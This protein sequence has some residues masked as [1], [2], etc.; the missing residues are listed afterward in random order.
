MRDVEVTRI[1]Y[2][3]FLI[4]GAEI[5][6]HIIL[7]FH[8]V[9]YALEAVLGVGN[10]SRYEVKFLKLEGDNSSL[11]GVLALDAVGDGERLFL[12]KNGSTRVALALCGKPIGLIA[13]GGKIRLSDLHFCLLQ[14]EDIGVE[15]GKNI[16][17]SLA[18][19]GTEAVYVPG[20]EFHLVSS[21]FC[22]YF[23]IT[24]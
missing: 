18:K 16:G 13:L 23:S 6:A 1:N 7:K 9:I 17:K 2:G 19:H 22:L 8:T 14:A 4:E 24:K 21:R 20:Y 15:R 5:C 10:I 11:V 3:L 12:R